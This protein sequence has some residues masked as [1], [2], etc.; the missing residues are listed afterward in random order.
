MMGKLSN[1]DKMHMPTLHKQ[2]FVAKATRTSYPDKTGARWTRFAVGSMSSDVT[3]R[4]GS[5]TPKYVLLQPVNIL[6]TL[7]KY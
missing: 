1:E 3:R 6:N 5:G 2:G 7:F 4:A